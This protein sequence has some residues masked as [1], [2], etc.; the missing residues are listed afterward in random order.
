MEYK[1]LLVD[2][3]KNIINALKRALYRDPYEILSANTAMEAL[4]IF[5]EKDIDLVV[6]DEVMPGMKGSEFLSLI[7]EAY[8]R[9][10]RIMLTGHA[11]LETAVRAINKGQIY[12]FLTK[13]WNDVDLAVTIR[14]ALEHRKLFMENQRLCAENKR[15]HGIL[16]LLDK[17]YPGITNVH[18]D[19]Q[20]NILL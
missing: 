14:Q 1:I 3:D 4:A 13:P 19:S 8:P 12:R 15:Q 18:R 20:G 6:S 7:S 10:V 16:L 2:D 11:T 17:K 9:T 5:T